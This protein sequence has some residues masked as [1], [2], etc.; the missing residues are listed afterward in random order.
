MNTMLKSLLGS[1]IVGLTMSTPAWAAE[2][3]NLKMAD[4]SI[5]FPEVKD[6]Y[7]DQVALLHK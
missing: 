6:S 4:E 2:Q 3:L 7:L 5:H 1:A